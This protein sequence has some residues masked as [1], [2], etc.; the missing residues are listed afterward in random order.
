MKKFLVFLI[1]LFIMPVVTHAGSAVNNVSFDIKQD[2]VEVHILP[3]GSANV[4]QLL[5]YD[6]SF[7]GVFAKI[8]YMNPNLMASSNNYENNAIYNFNGISNFKLSAKN[9][10]RVTFDTFD[11]YGF[12]EFKE[13]DYAYKGDQ[14]LYTKDTYA[15][16]YKYTIYH[17]THNDT[18][19]FLLE[20]TL[21]DVVV[22]HPDVAE[23][24]WQILDDDKDKEE[25]KDV[26]VRVYLPDADTKDTFRI[27]THD[28]L[29]S[30]IKYIEENGELIGFE[31]SADKV[32]HGDQFDVRATFNKDLI[33]DSSTLDYFDGEGFSGILEVEQRRA[34]EANA[35]R[36]RLKRIYNFFKV[37]SKVLL[38]AI[39]CAFVF[40]KYLLRKPKVDFQNVQYYR[41]FIDDYNVEVIDYLFKKQLT[42]NA[43][44]AAIMNLIY[45][46]KVT[47]EEV[48]SE[49]K[50]LL[51]NS[52]DYKFTLVDREGLDESNA[53]LVSF[54]F[55]KV[56]N[57]SEFTT[58]GLKKYAS[59]L[60][61]GSKF[62]SSYTSWNKKVISEGKKQ[63]FYKS[64]SKPI[65]IAVVLLIVSF[66][67]SIIGGNL[68]VDYPLVY[69][70]LVVAIFLMVYVGSA[71]AYSEKGTLHLKMWKAFKNFLNDFGK[72][73]IKELPEVVLWE[74]Y[75][76]YAVIFG[77]AKKVQKDMNVKIKELEEVGQTTD[78]LNTFTNLYIYDSIRSTFTKAVADGRRSYAASRANAYSSSS[79]GGGFGGG[80]SFGGG[81]GGGGGSHGGF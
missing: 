23:F 77:L 15:G 53:E 61:T 44:S 50:K 1:S 17:A 42:P 57:G 79:S 25:E 41:E 52:K 32:G 60:S 39:A 49:K 19:A 33:T 22:M 9:V 28:I 78:T 59:S 29:D 62:N 70:D 65:I 54:L 6:G 74:R 31:A 5:V 67:F 2:Y 63:G 20:Y 16:S 68:G 51:D 10:S 8:A 76:V 11:D 71:K 30:N 56:G 80:G 66:L 36:A 48:V 4:K 7:N 81:F 75:L 72:F 55:D 47:A 18:V 69:L 14:Y 27:W 12:K 34:D 24:Y 35:E 45:L 26:K 13:T 3:N 37:A 58:K 38:G 64:K 40:I 21:D 73:D 46:K 43:L